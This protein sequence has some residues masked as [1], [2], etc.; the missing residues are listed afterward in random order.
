MNLCHL[1]G[2]PVRRTYLTFVQYK[3]KMEN[4]C[5]MLYALPVADDMVNLGIPIFIAHLFDLTVMQLQKENELP[6]IGSA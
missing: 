3:V 1:P 5:N 2:S 6:A 4:I